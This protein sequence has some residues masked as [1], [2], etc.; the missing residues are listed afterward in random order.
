[1]K[2]YFP[3]EIAPEVTNK[4]ISDSKNFFNEFFNFFG[5][6]SLIVPPSIISKLK[7]SANALKYGNNQ[8]LSICI[9][10]ENGGKGS[11]IPADMSKKI[12]EYILKDV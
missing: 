7:V 9:L 2:S 8:K 6:L 5:S 3:A 4:F 11:N 1:M 12:F 10:I